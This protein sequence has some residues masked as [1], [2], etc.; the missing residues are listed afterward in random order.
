MTSPAL[1]KKGNA[2]LGLNMMLGI[3]VGVLPAHAPPPAPTPPAPTIVTVPAPMV[4]RTTTLETPA[5]AVLPVAPSVS[6]KAPVPSPLATTP[7][8]TDP[9]VVISS[10]SYVLVYVDTSPN[11]VN[12]AAASNTVTAAYPTLAECV[13]VMG[14]VPNANIVQGCQAE[15]YAVTTDSGS[16]GQ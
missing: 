12:G 9:T 2:M 7:T 16:L 3:A 11:P 15:S 4:G 1:P 6:P 13:A 14:T 10:T 5:P 8:T